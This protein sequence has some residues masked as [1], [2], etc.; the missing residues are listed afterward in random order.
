MSK[1][2]RAPGAHAEEPAGAGQVSDAVRAKVVE[3]AEV[4][5]TVTPT[6]PASEKA[7][8]MFIALR[9]KGAGVEFSRAVL[10][11]FPDPEP[12]ET[13]GEYGERVLRKVRG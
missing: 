8:F 6:D 9:T 1:V 10:A 5:C 13:E 2:I 12:G 11:V 7:L 3:I 4:L